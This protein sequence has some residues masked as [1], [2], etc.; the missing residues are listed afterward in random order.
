MDDI[1]KLHTSHDTYQ[2]RAFSS[3][4]K[5]PPIRAPEAVCS[6][7]KRRPLLCRRSKVCYYIGTGA[8]RIILRCGAREEQPFD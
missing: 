7:H 4:A 5:R 8:V 3:C 2:S 1:A 6:P